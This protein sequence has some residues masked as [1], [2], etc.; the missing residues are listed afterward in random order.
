MEIQLSIHWPSTIRFSQLTEAIPK[1][2]ARTNS[3]IRNVEQPPEHDLS[4]GYEKRWNFG[5]HV[6]YSRFRVKKTSLYGFQRRVQPNIINS[7]R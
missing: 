1:W 5:M 4:S 6:A 7:C 3:E 2:I